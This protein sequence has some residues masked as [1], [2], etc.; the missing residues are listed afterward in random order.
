MTYSILQQLNEIASN[1]YPANPNQINQLKDLTKENFPDINY[2]LQLA[3]L[4][5]TALPFC[6]SFYSPQSLNE[7]STS[8]SEENSVLFQDSLNDVT[9][10]LPPCSQQ[11]FL[12]LINFIIHLVGP[13]Y[14]QLTGSRNNEGTNQ[15]EIQKTNTTSAISNSAQH[16]GQ[17]DNLNNTIY[18]L[19]Q[20]IA[21]IKNS[22]HSSSQDSIL[23]RIK[24]LENSNNNTNVD[25]V[26]PKDAKSLEL[27]EIYDS[28]NFS[29]DIYKASAKGFLPIV[30][31]GVEYKNIDPRSPNENGEFPIL[32]AA[33]MGHEHIVE[34][35]VEQ[36]I[37]DIDTINKV[38]NIA[39]EN[40]RFPV[41]RYL[42]D[43]TGVDPYTQDE[44]GNTFLHFACQYGYLDLVEY[45]I[46]KCSYDVNFLNESKFAPLHTAICYGHFDIV[47]Y[48]I[49]K[50]NADLAI[51]TNSQRSIIHIACQ[52]NQIEVLNYLLQHPNLPIFLKEDHYNSQGKTPVFLACENGHLEIVKLLHEQYQVNLSA[53]DNEGHTLIHIACIKNY[54]EIVNYL[55]AIPSIREKSKNIAIL[56]ACLYG[57]LQT[58]KNLNGSNSFSFSSYAENT[59]LYVA[60]QAG[61]I[62]IVDY[63]IQNNSHPLIA[64]VISLKVACENNKQQ[65]ILHILHKYY[66]TEETKRNGYS[67]LHIACINDLLYAVKYLIQKY[68]DLKDTKDRFGK[69]PLHIASQNNYIKI[70]QYLIQNANVDKEAKDNDSWTALHYAIF[71]D[72]Y[73]VAHFLMY[74]AHVNFGA[75]TSNGCNCLHIACMK[76]NIGIVQ[77]LCEAPSIEHSTIKFFNKSV[78]NDLKT[79]AHYA[80]ANGHLPIVQC[81]FNHHCANFS[82]KDNFNKTSLHYACANGHLTIVKYLIKNVKLN[83]NDMDVNGWQPI[84]YACAY[85]HGSIVD[86]LIK[87]SANFEAKTNSND[88]KKTPLMITCLNRS[89]DVVRLLIN[90]LNLPQTPID[91]KSNIF[92]ASKSSLASISYL[93]ENKIFSKEFPDKNGNTPLHY[94]SSAGSLSIVQYLIEIAKANKRPKNNKGSK[95]L[96]TACQHNQPE[97]VQY[98]MDKIN[99]A[100]KSQYYAIKWAC[101]NG[102]LSLVQN[103]LMKGGVSIN[104]VDENGKTLMHYACSNGKIEIVQYLIQ[105]C[106]ALINKRDYYGQTPLHIASMTNN[107]SLV[108]TLINSGASPKARDNCGN[109]PIHNAAKANQKLIVSFYINKL[110]ISKELING[111]MQTPL[112][113]ACASGSFETLKYLIEGCHVNK[114]ARDIYER[115]PLHIAAINNHYEIVKYLIEKAFV[116]Y[117]AVNK[118]GNTILHY[119]AQ[120]GCLDIVKYLIG[121]LDFPINYKTNTYNKTPL[122]QACDEDKVEI[123]QY[124][125]KHP[126]IT[127]D[128]ME[129]VMDWALNKSQMNVIEYLLERETTQ[130]TNEKALKWAQNTKHIPII[131][132]LIQQNNVSKSEKE[133]VFLWAV[134]KNYEGIIHYLIEQNEINKNAINEKGETALHIA[135]S[136]GNLNIVKYLIEVAKLDKEARSANQ[137]TPLHIA[138]HNAHLDIVKYLVDEAHVN[139]QPHD[140]YG[141]TPYYIISHSYTHN[142][143]LFIPYL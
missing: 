104:K 33:K 106:P 75:R 4:L 51:R 32:I 143:E 135:C 107:L 85:N 43:N 122:H 31:F 12:I 77:L 73:D 117:I 123:I 128:T 138:C 99:P 22:I 92:D 118:N 111:N 133:K 50:A 97:V 120:K 38:V 112:H 49:E 132:F 78:D 27:M 126:H 103:I 34:Y 36:G 17:N 80:C 62:N 1:D 95:P 35:L 18:N 5:S 125:I 87:Q 121:F 69:T 142:Q 124:L 59:P 140:I 72:C 54:S 84:H 89:F 14:S 114:E 39:I 29:P 127:E 46:E 30:K 64:V 110:N 81:L 76:N 74:D 56:W 21:Q 45:F 40:D 63:I 37:N 44:N 10:C 94:A 139:K 60:A 13:L 16:I 71:N 79:P 57:K 119:A 61:H 7:N 93:I 102:Y 11:V 20:E 65:L 100:Q 67:L 86:F 131:Q 115:T 90:K 129:Y 96:H 88:G 58:L 136:E 55:I 6:K 82:A 83:V 105:N 141:R 41:I 19:E 26:Q 53:T 3:T 48:L 28:L 15:P 25:D 24:N 109:F 130:S 108:R 2:S 116:N 91:F 113:I 70:V 137:S 68:P 8:E 23:S 47:K 66:E 134:N 52:Y 9:S 42:I 98:F 101:M